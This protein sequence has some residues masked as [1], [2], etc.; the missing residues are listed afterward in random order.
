[1]IDMPTCEQNVKVTFVLFA[2]VRLELNHVYG[3]HVSPKIFVNSKRFYDLFIAHKGWFITLQDPSGRPGVFTKG[4]LAYG[5]V[6][7]PMRP[8]AFRPAILLVV[9][10]SRHAN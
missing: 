9:S 4:R 10:I 5:L 1:M 6:P 3:R 8:L 2:L 7:G